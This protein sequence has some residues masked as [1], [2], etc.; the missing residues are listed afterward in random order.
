MAKP[1]VFHLPR[2][3]QRV[4]VIGST[5][6]GKTQAG[7]W[8]LSERSID[9]IPW[10]ILDYKRDKLINKI[11]FLKEA[12][13]TD[14]I[15]E[16][17][18]VYIVHPLPDEDEAVEQFLWNIWNHENVGLFIDEAY[19]LKKSPAFRALL[20]QGRSKNIPM[21]T[22][23]QRPVWVTQFVF[24]EANYYQ[25]FW[26]QHFQD[27]KTI[28][29]YLS[30]DLEKR[31]SPYWSVWYDISADATFVLKP[32]PGEAQ[33]LERFRSRLGTVAATETAQKN[34]K[35]FRVI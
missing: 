31:L 3:D 27:R 30:F 12:T 19:M 25:I 35:R 34:I 9:V 7:V 1:P 24:S 10:Y 29:P 23:T 4:V 22:L 6:G 16:T 32:V 17:P 14:P 26:L 15:A 18:G 8:Q 33:I 13:L 2:D 20:T 28:Q 21:I 5:G 11:P